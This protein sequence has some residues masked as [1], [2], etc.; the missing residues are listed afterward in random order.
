M[1][2]ASIVE[3]H[4]NDRVGA[5]PCAQTARSADPP[6]RPRTPPRRRQSTAAARRTA[7][8]ATSASDTNV[9]A[10]S[11]TSSGST[12]GV[13]S[14]VIGRSVGRNQRQRS[15]VAARPRSD[16]P[17]RI[18]SA[19]SPAATTRPT[20]EYPGPQSVRRLGQ[21]GGPVVAFE[22]ILLGAGADE[23]A[24]WPP[25]GV[26]RIA[27]IGDRP[28]RRLLTSLGEGNSIWRAVR[29]TD[30]TNWKHR[31]RARMPHP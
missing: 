3:I 8:K 11:E 30:S 17:R 18:R 23:R 19:S 4:G 21:A 26:A 25:P 22:Q 28:S 31:A 1:L 15:R 13:S 5:R 12:C 6:R 29:G 20:H 14:M 27:G 2:Q 24:R 7:C 10:S 16:R 9:A